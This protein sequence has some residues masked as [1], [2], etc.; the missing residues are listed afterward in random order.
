MQPPQEAAG[1]R[2]G[3]GVRARDLTRTVRGGPILRGVSLDVRPGELLAIVGGSGAGKTTLLEA[4]A[5]VRPADAGTV[6][7]GGVPLYRNL[8]GLRGALGYVPQDDIIHLDLPL[9]R[10]LRYAARLR[11]APETT[12]AE[13][14]AAVREVLAALDLS[15]HADVRVGALSGGQRKRASIAVELLMRPRVFFL[16][17][18]TSGLDPATSAELLRVLRRLAASGTTVIF[19][20]HAIQDLSRVDRVAFLARGGS[21]A[22]AGTVA[23]ALA[24]FG[25]NEVDEVYERL[26]AEPAAAVPTAGSAVTGPSGGATAPPEVPSPRR[27]PGAVRQWAVLTRRTLETLVRSRLTMAIML[28]SPVMIVAMFA[29]LFRPGAFDFADPS[30]S[31]IVMIIF[32][33]TFGAFFFG[34]TYGLLQIC[35]ERA[36]VRRE[37]LVGLRLGA[38]LLSKVAVLLPFLVGVVVLMLA[39]LRGLDRM[40]AADLGTYAS[41][42][43]TLTL[44]AT[45]GLTMGLLTSAAVRDPSQAT[46]ALPM[47]CFPAVLFSGAILPVHVMAGIGAAISLLVPDRWAFEAVGRDLGVRTLLEEGGSPLGPPLVATYG[48]AGSQATPVYW[49]ILA[50]FALAFLLAAW[51]VLRRSCLRDER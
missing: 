39:V 30:P 35:T 28:G 51:P 41:V 50:A 2:D 40:P 29:V 38:Y 7:Y 23:E 34:L 16:D 12:D 49:A 10:T 6:E 42:A 13:I 46:L 43:V 5:G 18:P 1:A 9:A 17:E 48:D 21:L 26:A 33:V 14:G 4:L 15:A 3:V 32:W 11:L 8:A 31:A 19:T 44:V 22:F 20:T 25:V 27:Q 37:H 47:L 36:I 45:A 24:H